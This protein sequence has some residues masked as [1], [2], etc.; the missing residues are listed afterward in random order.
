MAPWNVPLKESSKSHAITSAI[1]GMIFQRIPEDHRFFALIS[2]KM[3]EC[4]TFS[5]RRGEVQVGGVLD[6]IDNATLGYGGKEFC[7]VEVLGQRSHDLHH[8]YQMLH[9]QNVPFI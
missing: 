7:D 2:N 5:G 1:F 8:L 9:V 4:A 3:L 6:A